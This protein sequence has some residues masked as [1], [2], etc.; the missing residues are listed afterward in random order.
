MA[1][2]NRMAEASLG[3]IPTTRDRRI[4]SLL[5]RSRG[6][7]D[8]IFCHWA[9]GKPAKAR[10]S[11][12]CCTADGR[13]VPPLR[14]QCAEAS[15]TGLELGLPDRARALLAQAVSHFAT[16][17]ATAASDRTPI[18]SPIG[19][20][21]QAHRWQ[22]LHGRSVTAAVPAV[23]PMPSCAPLLFAK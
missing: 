12:L 2:T 23:Q 11:V 18:T 3:K 16:C 22:R 17:P 10:T 15:C 8:Q 5:M 13:L 7:V 20:P 21:P 9:L 1:P 19:G 14:R 6:L 4:I